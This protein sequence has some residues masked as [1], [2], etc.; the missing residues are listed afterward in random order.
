[1]LEKKRFGRNILD[2]LS[3][4]KMQRKKKYVFEYLTGEPLGTE[5]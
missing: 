2:T 1:M 4:K 3:V 5:K